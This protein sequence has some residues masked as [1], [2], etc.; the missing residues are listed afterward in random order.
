M[1]KQSSDRLRR[2]PDARMHLRIIWP[3]HFRRGVH[4]YALV[5]LARSFLLSPE[6][7]SISISR[8]QCMKEK[9]EATAPSAELIGCPIL[10]KLNSTE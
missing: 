7:E 1:P 3:A 4:I 5:V 9:C 6:Y 2:F 10:T 8:F